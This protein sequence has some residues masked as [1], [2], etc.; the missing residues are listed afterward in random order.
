[1]NSYMIWKRRIKG[2]VMTQRITFT[3]KEY[4]PDYG[5]AILAP[6]HLNW[7]DSFLLSSLISRQIH[8]VGTHELF[9]A[10]NCTTYFIDYMMQRIGTWFRIPAEF[11]SRS[12]AEMISRRINELGVIPVNRGGA[13]RKMLEKVEEGLKRNFLVCIFPEGG[14]GIK[15]RLNKFKKGLSKIVY[16]LWKEGYKNIPV[17][18]VAIRGTD[19]FYMP[20]RQIFL[21][22]GQP[23]R[24]DDCIGKAE[25]DTLNE[26]TYS[27]WKSN[28]RL[29]FHQ[30]PPDEFPEH[31]S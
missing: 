19:K 25:K 3:G 18:P 22:I 20:N 27:L 15:G 23:L 5:A 14:T 30:K 24:I 1:M 10:D 2:I 29:L 31:G 13:V 4:I 11:V 21:E 6:N 17:L 9:D 8:Y 12:L 16:D 28:Y 26:F 7:K